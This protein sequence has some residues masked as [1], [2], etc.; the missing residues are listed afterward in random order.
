MEVFFSVVLIYL[1][2]V[3]EE[4]KKFIFD[5]ETKF[6]DHIFLW[7]DVDDDGQCGGSRDM[8]TINDWQELKIFFYIEKNFQQKK[9]FIIIIAYFGDY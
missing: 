3:R 1:L 9:S 7:N 8:I 6:L 5:C 2:S 4:N